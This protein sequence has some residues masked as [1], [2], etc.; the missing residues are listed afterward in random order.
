M[1]GRMPLTFTEIDAYL[2]ST[3]TT[4]TGDEVMIIR[5]MSENYCSMANDR[6]PQ[7]KAP[8]GNKSVIK[9]SF[10]EALKGIAKP[11]KI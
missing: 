4:L 9:N 2:R 11:A 5:R 10:V 8:Y 7:T 1:G 3:E 6:N